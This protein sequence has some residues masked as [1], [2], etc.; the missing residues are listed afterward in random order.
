VLFVPE[1]LGNFSFTLQT[2]RSKGLQTWADCQILMMAS[3][4]LQPGTSTHLVAG[5]WLER[6]THQ[7]RGTHLLLMAAWLSKR[8]DLLSLA[9][10]AD[11]ALLIRSWLR[12]PLLTWRILRAPIRYPQ[13]WSHLCHHAQARFQDARPKQTTTAIHNKQAAIQ[14]ELPP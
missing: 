3:L 9:G 14:K 2:A 13:L 11:W 5:L 8:R 12:H 1:V 4:F 7:P 6:N 10:L